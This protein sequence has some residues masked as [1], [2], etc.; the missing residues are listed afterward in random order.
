[1]TANAAGKRNIDQSRRAAAIRC[2][3]VAD[4]NWFSTMK[5]VRI[6]ARGRAGMS[7]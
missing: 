4:R 2:A 3:R 5:S 1:M 6:T 7:W